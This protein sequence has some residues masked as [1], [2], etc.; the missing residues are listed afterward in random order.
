[1][2]DKKLIVIS[3]TLAGNTCGEDIICFGGGIFNRKEVVKVTGST[4]SEN[5]G[6]NGAGIYNWEGVLT[7]TQSTFSGNLSS[8]VIYNQIATATVESSTFNDNS[9]GYGGG[10]I[11]NVLG[12]LT[13]LNSTI[14]NNSVISLGG[15]I[16]TWLAIENE[17]GAIVL[18]SAFT[19]VP[20]MGARTYPFLPIRLLCRTQYN[21]L[22]RVRHIAVPK[23]ICHSPTDEV[24]PYAMGERLM[25]AAME[26]KFF[27]EMGGG[28]NITTF[29]SRDR[30]DDA[31]LRLAAQMQ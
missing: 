25:Q 3:S 4:L 10:G 24:V 15:G 11:L 18:E 8:T 27:V 28:H 6:W 1:M 23:L 13:L 31:L 7:V 21:N 20:D 14:S 12:S 17:P 22:E 19:S 29:D 9:G 5:R 30:L 2:N 16:A 26:P